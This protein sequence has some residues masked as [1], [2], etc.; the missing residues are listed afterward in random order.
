MPGALAGIRVV[1]FAQY[2]QGP[3]CG[4][5]LGDMG[6]DV[7]K[8]E[9]PG[10][11]DGGRVPGVLGEDDDST[12]FLAMNRNK[13]SV[14]LDLKH[15]GGAEAARE[16]IVTADVVIENFRPGTMDRLG[17]GYESMSEL[18]P[19]LVFASATGW[20][21]SGP[22]VRLP[23]HDLP[24]QARSGAMSVGGSAGQPP[25]PS[26]LF[27]ADGIGSML[28]AFAVV[29]AL[30][31]RQQTG[32]GQRVETSLL[33]ALIHMQTLELTTYMNTGVPP[34]RGPAGGHVYMEGPYGTYRA[35]DGYLVLGPMPIVELAEV[36]D[37]PQVPERFA[38]KRQLWREREALY[39]LIAPVIERM[40]VDH[41]LGEFEQRG[42]ACG[43]V[44]D[45]D[46]VIA[47]PQVAANSMLTEIEDPA[48]GRLRV[49]GIP[50]RFS[51]TA[52][53][54]RMPPPRL[55]AHTDEVLAELG[56][57]EEAI[58][59]LRVSGAL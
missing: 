16:L 2:M 6:A 40:P 23:G 13:R 18:N 36:L 10:R 41:W 33:N 27:V 46:A 35:A 15:D 14:T 34:R 11:G 51:D 24:A 7:I 5:L 42:I 20:G 55:G 12:F 1:E 9:P 58:E 54:I 4:Q 17:L 32:R 19:D 56:F 30:Q 29:V 25:T 28:L 21:S 57:N 22:L 43:P 52:A 31:A 26:G 3:W 39:A 44:N 48:R 49:T 38:D 45:Y 37:L 8:V 50:I 53:E 47:D 59:Q